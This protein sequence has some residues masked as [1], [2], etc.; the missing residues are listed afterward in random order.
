LEKA[1][2]T[3]AIREALVQYDSETK[4]PYVE[5]ETGDQQFERRDVELGISDGIFVEVKNGITK[6]DKIKVWNQIQGIPSYAQN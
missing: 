5:I 3:V 2:N 6:E 1:E 4:K